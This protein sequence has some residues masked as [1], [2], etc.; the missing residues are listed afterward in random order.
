MKMQTSQ[1]LEQGASRDLSLPSRL[2]LSDGAYSAL[3][4]ANSDL[5]YLLTI[6]TD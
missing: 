1:T 5:H 2:C 6:P 4:I 3:D